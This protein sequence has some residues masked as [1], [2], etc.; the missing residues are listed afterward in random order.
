MRETKWLASCLAAH[1]YNTFEACCTAHLDIG[2][3]GTQHGVVLEEV[4]GLLDS[5]GVVQCHNLDVGVLAPVSSTRGRASD[6]R[7]CIMWSPLLAMLLHSLPCVWLRHLEWLESRAAS[8][9]K[10]AWHAY[11]DAL[12]KE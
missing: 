9:H 12:L 3:K 11:Q 2:V 7:P 10:A 5:P 8:T 1:S 6:H 4:A